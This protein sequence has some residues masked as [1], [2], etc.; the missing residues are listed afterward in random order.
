MKAQQVVFVRH[1]VN[2]CMRDQCSAGLACGSFGRFR[3]GRVLCP[4]YQQEQVAILA[5]D[6]KVNDNNAPR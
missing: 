6:D 1:I 4:V 3:L 2:M 5:I